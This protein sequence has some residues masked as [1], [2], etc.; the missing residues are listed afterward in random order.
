VGTNLIALENE[1]NTSI[2]EMRQDQDEI[3][4]CSSVDKMDIQ[5]DDLGAKS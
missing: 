3:S 5:N 2:Q 1:L 4:D